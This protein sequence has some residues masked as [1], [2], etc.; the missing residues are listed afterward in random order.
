MINKV[1]NDS[2]DYDS[3][4][5]L[6]DTNSKSKPE[7][8][9]LEKK[10]KKYNIELIWSVPC[11]EGLLLKMLKKGFRENNADSKKCKSI[12]KN[13]Y[14][15]KKENWGIQLLEKLFPKETIEIKKNKIP[16]LEKLIHIIEDD[17]CS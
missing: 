14:N 7:I 16:V 8:Q 4:Y 10:A 3:K 11:L 2:A 9:E 12:F 5:I 17:N 6:L 1:K 13:E 15:N